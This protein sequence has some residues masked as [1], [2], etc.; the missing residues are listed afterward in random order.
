MNVNVIRSG[1]RSLLNATNNVHFSIPSSRSYAKK[2][3]VM[4]VL[5]L[6]RL[7]ELSGR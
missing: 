1:F 4:F 7:L 2:G 3:I 6:F 5:L